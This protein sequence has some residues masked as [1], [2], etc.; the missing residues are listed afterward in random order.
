MKYIALILPLFLTGCFKS[1]PVKMSFPDAPSEMKTVCS[2][3]KQVKDNA[4]MSDIL[5]VVTTNYAKYHECK[6][7]VDAWI[8]W[9]KQQKQI[10]D[11]VK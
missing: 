3:L 11:S 4:E 8:E 7:K 1:I 6:N 10:S 5:E 2:E 9:H